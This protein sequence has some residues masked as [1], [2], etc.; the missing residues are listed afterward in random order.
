MPDWLSWQSMCSIPMQGI[1]LLKGF[2]FFLFYIVNIFPILSMS[3]RLI[4]P[5]P[6]SNP[7]DTWSTD[8][9]CSKCRRRCV[10]RQ[11]L[12]RS[13]SKTL[14]YPSCLILS[15]PCLAAFC[16][17]PKPPSPR[18]ALPMPPGF[19]QFSYFPSV[20]LSDDLGGRR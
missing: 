12:G 11:W 5:V 6:R 4:V 9:S 18:P 20:V 7:E 10:V 14:A 3:I 2:F 17:R 1:E 13:K 8:L 15:Q 16:S 19:L